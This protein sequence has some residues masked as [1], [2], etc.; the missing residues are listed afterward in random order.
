MHVNYKCYDLIV[1]F[2]CNCMN[3][4][5]L[6]LRHL[7]I[8]AF[9]LDWVAIVNED[10]NLLGH[11]FESRF[12]D[13][14]NFERLKI[15][16]SN[17]GDG[18]LVVQ[19]QKYHYCFVHDFYKGIVG[20]YVDKGEFNETYNKYSRRIRRLYSLIHLSE[21]VLFVCNFKNGSTIKNEAIVT[22]QEEIQNR[23][24]NTKINLFAVRFNSDD[25]GLEKLANDVYVNDVKG[26]ERIEIA[27]SWLN[28]VKIS[29][30]ILS[31]M[32]CPVL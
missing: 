8:R 1:P 26:M 11:L 28:K 15:V 14:L 30:K 16:D 24:V 27:F 17:S 32:K 21:R 23:C 18:H 6:S 4:S 25:R 9:P 2:G 19:D 5:Q 20:G 29:G 7:R 10:C 22:L 12:T 13:F 31:G 3:A